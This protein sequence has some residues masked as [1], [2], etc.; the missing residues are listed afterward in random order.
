MQVLNS[1][2][3]HISMQTERLFLLRI[4][5]STGKDLYSIMPEDKQKYEIARSIMR[6][7][8]LK[9]IIISIIPIMI[10]SLK[11]VLS[12]CLI[13]EITRYMRKMSEVF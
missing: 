7:T 4:R 8:L 11:I 12:I 6:M 2:M 3:G 1:K 13:P 9:F 10:K 5:M